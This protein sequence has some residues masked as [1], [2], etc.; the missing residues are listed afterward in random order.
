MYENEEILC[1]SID[2]DKTNI[3]LLRGYVEK[4]NE[5]TFPKWRHRKFQIK[6]RFY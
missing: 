4:I 6:K 5:E 2:E 3:V 1:A